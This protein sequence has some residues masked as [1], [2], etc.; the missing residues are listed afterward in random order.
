MLIFIIGGMLALLTHSSCLAGENSI[1]QKK[2][3]PAIYQKLRN[4]AL[5][6]SREN[7]GLPPAKNPAEPWGV[8]MDT[9]F[10]DG[11]SYTV[12]S[13][14]DGNASIYL[15][16]GGGWIGGIEH[17]PLRDAAQTVVKTA[18]KFQPKMT[19]TTK[20]PLPKNGGTTF[21]ILTDKGVFTASA[22]EVDLGE[23]R[24]YL[25]PLFYAAQEVATHYRRIDESKE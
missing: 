11:G 20:Y 25:S 6:G 17:K 10:D 14:E 23:K 16:S 2:A 7:F 21:Y 13:I 18:R 5:S 12:V 3:A 9:T 19:M 8:V 15:S 22:L 4:Q 24:H 1:A